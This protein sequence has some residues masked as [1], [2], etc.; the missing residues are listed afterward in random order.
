MK[1]YEQQHRTIRIRTYIHFPNKDGF[2]FCIL[3][4]VSDMNLS[5]YL[6]KTEKKE[7]RY[8]RRFYIENKEE[9]ISIINALNEKIK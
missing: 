6:D 3:L 8:S 7:K 4:Q 1:I 9:A 2:V 5:E